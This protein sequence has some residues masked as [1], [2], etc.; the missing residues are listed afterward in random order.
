MGIVYPSHLEFRQKIR[1][2]PHDFPRRI[3]QHAKEHYYDNLT[4]HYIALHQIRFEGELR[5]MALAYDQEKDLVEIITLHPIKPYQ[6]ISRI[7]SGRWIK[8]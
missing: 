8:L 3:F 6:K 1:G 2:I 4:K 7:N 5:E